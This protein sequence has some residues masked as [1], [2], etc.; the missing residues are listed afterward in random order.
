MNRFSRVALL[1]TVLFPALGSAALACP[2]CY[3]NAEGQM[4]DAARLGMF[5]LLGIV[6]LMQG[7]FGAFFLYLRRQARR[8]E[9][10][11][12]DQEWSKL[13]REMAGQYRSMNR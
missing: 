11:A 2:V 9:S 12:L 8:A 10:A 6:V 5:L 4:I 3:G 13:Q 1:T 7:A